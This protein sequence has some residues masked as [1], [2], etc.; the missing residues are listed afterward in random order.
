MALRAG[1]V[2]LLNVEQF[3]QSGNVHDSLAEAYMNRVDRQLAIENYGRS[4]ELDPGNDNAREQLAV[5]DGGGN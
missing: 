2:S 5:L 1:R 4:L 3:P